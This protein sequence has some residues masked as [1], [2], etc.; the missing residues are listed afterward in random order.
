MDSN[1]LHSNLTGM[2][3]KDFYK[4]YNRMGYGFLEKVYENSL[5]IELRK[6]GLQCTSQFSVKVYYDNLQVGFYMA[7]I[8]VNESV[9]IEI[10]AAEA[11]CEQHE[12][13]LTNYLSNRY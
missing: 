1:Y 8:I 2:I 10:K 4:V 12:A 9:I 13:Q 5:I 6:Q 3:I 7:D 11:L